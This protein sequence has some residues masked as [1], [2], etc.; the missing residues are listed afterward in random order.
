MAPRSLLYL[1]AGNDFQLLDYR[2]IRRFS[3]IYYNDIE[4]PT[5]KDKRIEKYIVDDMRNMTY[6]KDVTDV[7]FRNLSSSCD[8][9]FEL[10]RKYTIWVACHYNVCCVSPFEKIVHLPCS[11]CGDDGHCECKCP[12]EKATTMMSVFSS[13]IQRYGDNITKITIHTRDE[14]VELKEVYDNFHNWTD[15]DCISCRDKPRTE[16]SFKLTR[17]RSREYDLVPNVN[18]SRQKRSRRSR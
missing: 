1:G 12:R 7:L 10:S 6:P 15:C 16:L 18:C 11:L 3:K 5:Q 4:E 2:F 13:F 8:L 9:L 14:K 17:K